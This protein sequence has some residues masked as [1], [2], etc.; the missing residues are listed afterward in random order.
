M[1]QPDAKPQ[2]W[3]RRPAFW[4]GLLVSIASIFLLLSLIDI[5]GL[6]DQLSH[7]DLRFILLAA[8]CMAASAYFRAIRWQA[9]LGPD[10]R[11]R[12]IFHTENI[13][14]LLNALLPL[15]VGEAARI[16]LICRSKNRRPISPL[17]AL[18][19]IVLARLIDTLFVVLLLGL[20]LPALDVPDA[21]KAGGYT[22]LI[23]G[24]VAI[25]VLLVVAFAR[26][27]LLTLATAV[28][29]RLLP[30]ALTSRVINWLDNFLS[31]LVVLRS[32]GRLFTLVAFTSGLWLCYIG[33]YTAVLW[34]FWP[35]PPLA[36]SLL[37]TAAGSLSFVVPSSPSGIGV[38]HAVIVLAM[39]GY[40]T[41]DTAAA[42]AIVLNATELVVTVIIGIYSLAVTG[43]SIAG[44]TAAAQDIPQ[45]MPSVQ[46]E[47]LA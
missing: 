18:S 22:M 20:V 35:T 28:L 6:L 40:L 26:Q 32:P 27:W 29:E 13:S 9:I 38:F 46:P 47:S 21:V 19:T 5:H 1:S 42:Y 2:R 36:W 43:T 17:E 8:V 37:A 4:F 3:Y 31:G 25:V 12:N 45:D 7:A 34:A 23:L 10:I 15:R 24:L 16:V 11:F 30:A 14:Y 44:I 39:S 41:A 33:F